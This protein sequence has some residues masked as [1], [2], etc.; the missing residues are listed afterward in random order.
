MTDIERAKEL[1]YEKDFT[2]VLCKGEEVYTS[3]R[4]GISPMVDFITRQIDLRGFSAADKIVGKAAA[5]LFVLAGVSEVYAE[6]I[7]E[8]A[9]IVFQK[10]N[11][12]YS[13]AAMAKTIINRS[14]TDSCPME[15]AV[16]E[17]DEPLQA[18]TAIENTLKILR[19]PNTVK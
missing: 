18:L 6:V 5:M 8:R 10:Y 14:G 12:Q 15:L 7:S 16:A 3:Q 11:I 2:C 19:S 4:T 1:L 17:I 13:Y 9:V